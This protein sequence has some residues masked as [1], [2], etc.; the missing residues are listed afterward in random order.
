MSTAIGVSLPRLATAVGKAVSE[1]AVLGKTPGFTADFIKNKYPS[2]SSFASAITHS[3]SGNAVMTDGY[4]PELVTNGSFTNDISGWTTEA[5]SEVTYDDGKIRLTVANSTNRGA[6]QAIA[7]ESGKTYVI[8]AL[9]VESAHGNATVRVGTV[10]SGGDLLSEQVGAGSVQLSFTATGTTSYLLLRPNSTTNG[11]YVLFDNVSVREMPVLKWAPHNLLS[12]SEEFDNDT[13]ISNQS[14]TMTGNAGV[15]PDGTSTADRLVGTGGWFRQRNFTHTVGMV[16]TTNMW[17]KS[18]TGSNQT[19]RIYGDNSETS[20]NLTATNEWQLFSHEYT[21]SAGGTTG[22][23]I[24]RDTFNTDAD[25]LVWGHHTYRSDLGGMVDN[26]DQPPSRASYVPTTSSAVYLP[27]VGHHVFN[28]NAWVNEGLLAES[29]ARTNIVN[30][31]NEFTATNWS[32]GGV[33]V[34]S[35][36]GISPDG[37]NNAFKVSETATT[38]THI[39]ANTGTATACY[40]VFAKAGTNTRFRINSGASGNGYATFDL[41]GGT[42]IAESGTAFVDATMQDCG[43]GWYRCALAL[44]SSATSTFSIVLEDSSGNVSYTGNTANHLFVY[45]GQVE[46]NVATPSSYI[47]TPDTTSVT[48]AAETFTIPSA[49]LPWPSPQYIGSELVTNGTFDSDISGWTD[50]SNAGGSITW[51]A[52]GYLNL[53]ATTD[54]SRAAQSIAVT[55]G[56][57]YAVSL[58]VVSL[59]GSASSGLYLDG[60]VQGSVFSSTG[61]LTFYYVAVDSSLDV[62]VRNFSTGTTVSIDNISVREINPLS[63]S[64]AMDGRMTFADTDDANEALLYRWHIDFDNRLQSFLSTAGT[65]TGQMNFFQEENNVQDSVA[66]GND[67]YAT[68]ILTPFDIASRHGSTFV[69]GATEGVALTADTTPTALADLSSTDMTIAHVYMGTIGTFRV[70][71]KDITDAGLVEATNPS[72]EPS[73]SLTFE[74]TGTNSFIVNDWSE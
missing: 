15:A 1:Y 68:G 28:G 51:N 50:N 6:Y 5:D 59:G 16:L 65:R 4:G 41:S 67:Y 26:P 31:S 54:T 58:E 44:D 38:G 42:I 56:N 29:E 9:L 53:V 43:N 69:N 33:T 2:Y 11:N 39:C 30:K 36:A 3:R 23:G 63:V 12:Y 14:V 66:T 74:G 34:T 45:G 13:N 62:S 71:D 70:W 40:S 37:N 60:T 55:T 19:F 46:S 22:D 17:V 21:V 49:N 24:T 35:A 61:T 57:V 25:L 47:P 73:L 52:S 18:N 7:T 27:R 32:K 10:V 48:R 64:I 8:D 20:A 72:L